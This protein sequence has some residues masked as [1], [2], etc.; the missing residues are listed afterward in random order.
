MLRRRRRK[1]KII[2]LCFALL[3]GGFIYG[4]FTNE[5]QEQNKPNQDI[6]QAKA[7]IASVENDN[8]DSLSAN[9]PDDEEDNV[10]SV[11]Q[12]DNIVTNNTKLIFKTYYERTRDT[13]INEKGIPTTFVGKSLDEL[14]A[15]L[16]NNFSD[17][18][19]RDINKDLVELYQVSKQVSPNHYVIKDYNGYISVF[20]IDE[21][22]NMKLLN[23]TEIPISSLGNV[24]QQKMTEGIIVK[25]I[26][27]ITQ[28]LEDYSS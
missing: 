2:V 16:E 18:S 27:G 9:I 15:Y 22:G 19:I 11:V 21:E 13:I 8:K 4:F 3:V 23:Q 10:F 17:W 5:G 12:N 20:Q 7:P 24:D 26:D 28:L 6:D 25:G 1:G 14:Q